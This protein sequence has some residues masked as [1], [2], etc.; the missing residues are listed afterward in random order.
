MA[1]SVNE[2]IGPFWVGDVPLSTSVLT[3]SDRDGNGVDLSSATGVISTIGSASLVGDTIVIV[4]PTTSA[5]SLAGPNLL[6]LTLTT[7][8]GSVT[9]EPAEYIVQ[10][11]TGWHTLDSARKSWRD[12]P[13]SD[14]A[15]YALLDT[16][17]VQVETY[18]SAL[19][20]PASVLPVGDGYADFFVAA[21][22]F[23]QVEEGYYS[24][25]GSPSTFVGDSDGYYAYT[26][27]EA[28]IVPLRYKQAQLMQTRNLWNAAKSD[29]SGQMGDDGF[30]IRP[31]PMDWVIKG[32]IRPKN[33]VPVVA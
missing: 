33:P 25:E 29:P 16:A 10:A 6:E 2:Q 1:Y 31:F 13:D 11:K 12:A 7:A 14:V 22:S 19:V 4:W 30:V 9:V 18:G 24:F 8:T 20:A 3:L 28:P 26:G 15:L 17:R 27:V 23:V 21:R 32:I 5:F